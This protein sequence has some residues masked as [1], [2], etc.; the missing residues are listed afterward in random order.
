MATTLIDH[1]KALE[2]APPAYSVEF[3]GRQLK[4]GQDY[5]PKEAYRQ[6]FD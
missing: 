5:S 3:G 4:P 6:V 1:L 2:P